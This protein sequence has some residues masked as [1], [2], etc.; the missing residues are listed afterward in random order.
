MGGG[1]GLRDTQRTVHAVLRGGDGSD[2]KGMFDSM[3][4]VCA[5]RE[6]CSRSRIEREP[7]RALCAL[8]Q[9][10]PSALSCVIVQVSSKPSLQGVSF[11]LEMIVGVVNAKVHGVSACS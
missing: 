9:S 7:N 3:R 8:F 10:K 1:G 11:S 6:K 4:N 2:V 5:V